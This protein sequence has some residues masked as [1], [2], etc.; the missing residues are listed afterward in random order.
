[1]FTNKHVPASLVIRS[2]P[3][4]NPVRGEKNGHIVHAPIFNV[5]EKTFIVE[6]FV[7]SSPRYRPCCRDRRF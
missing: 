3:L 7:F 2:D 1:M 4:E 6:S 5:D